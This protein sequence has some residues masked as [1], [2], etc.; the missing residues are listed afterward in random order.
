VSLE[1]T[2]RHIAEYEVRWQALR[3]WASGHEA[4]PLGRVTAAVL[5]EHGEPGDLSGSQG[6]EFYA[7]LAF[8]LEAVMDE[9]LD[10]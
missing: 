1:E 10:A 8:A 9:V 7:G 3:Q 2:R 6:P 5:A 4:E